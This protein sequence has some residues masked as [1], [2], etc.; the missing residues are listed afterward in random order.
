MHSSVAVCM[1]QL[2]YVSGKITVAGSEPG[3]LPLPQVS[4]QPYIDGR[5]HERL[6]ACDNIVLAIL[7]TGLCFSNTA[8][9]HGGS[10]GRSRMVSQRAWPCS[11]NMQAM[12]DCDY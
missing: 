8:S 4:L 6:T 5:K 12:K 1:R 7:I 10:C 9:L 3:T 2:L 11:K